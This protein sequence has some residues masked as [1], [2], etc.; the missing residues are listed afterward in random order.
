MHTS[1]KS[2]HSSTAPP[3]PPPVSVYSYRPSCAYPVY[4]LCCTGNIYHIFPALPYTTIFQRVPCLPIF[5]I[6]SSCQGGAA[7]LRPLLCII[8]A[9]LLRCAVVYLRFVHCACNYSTCTLVHCLP[10]CRVPC[11][12][13]CWCWWI[14]PAPPCRVRC[15]H[16]GLFLAPIMYPLPYSAR[17]VSRQYL[18]NH[19]FPNI[20]KYIISMAFF[21]TCALLVPAFSAILCSFSPYPRGSLALIIS[22]FS[23]IYRSFA[24]FFAAVYVVAFLSIFSFFLA[25]LH[26]ILFQIF[27]V[28]SLFILQ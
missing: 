6:I 4:T 12:L 11:P 18:Y 24:R 16:T 21:S 2:L 3:P 19:S 15:L 22:V 28:I 8:D 1:P 13:S 25:C 23:A 26:V 9:Y 17:K 10:R 7:R 20:S 27:F 5:S 14:Y